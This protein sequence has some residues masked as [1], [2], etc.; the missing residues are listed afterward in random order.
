MCDREALEPAS[1]V[2]GRK[3]ILAKSK[4]V[5]CPPELVPPDGKGNWVVKIY[6]KSAD[7]IMKRLAPHLTKHTL[8]KWEQTKKKCPI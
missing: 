2:F 6:G 1:R 5:R 7:N 4:R 3:I 8:E